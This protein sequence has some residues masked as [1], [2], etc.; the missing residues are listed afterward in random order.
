MTSTRCSSAWKNNW[1]LLGG[2]GG[3]FLGE[4]A[5]GAGKTRA[6]GEETGNGNS[7]FVTPVKERTKVTVS[8]YLTHTLMGEG[9]SRTL[10]KLE[11]IRRTSS[12]S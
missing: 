2:G 9:T 7:S 10:L 5:R 12:S 11:L 4:R 8:P 3:E 1:E 6:L